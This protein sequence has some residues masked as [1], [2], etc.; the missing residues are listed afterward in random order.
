MLTNGPDSGDCRALFNKHTMMKTTLLRSLLAAG[1]FL[2]AS[3]LATN[4]RAAAGD[5]YE[6]N[7]GNVLRFRL[8]SS[9]PA[10]FFTGLTNPKGLVFDG[11]GHLYIADPGKGAII[12]LSLPD[13]GGSTYASGLNSPT[14][15][16][17][18]AAGFLYVSEAGSGNI[19]KFAADRTKTTFAANTGASAG[20]VFD[21]NGNLFSAD[22]NGGN[23]FK[24]A[25]DG[26]KTTFATGLNH[27]AGLAIDSAGNLFEADSESGTI[28][29]FA[30]DG[31]KTSF[32][33][34]IG[35][36]Y[37]ITFD[38]NGDLI[39]A[40]NA[41]G[42]TLK[43]SPTGVKAVIFQSNFNTPQFVAVEPAQHTLLNISTRG[44]VQPGS[45]P[46]IAG[47]VV[48]GTGPV[49]TAI[50]IR[51]LGPSLSALGVAHPLPDPVVELH[52]ASGTLI[53][54]NNDWKDSQ[55][56]AISATTL[57]PT[58]DREAAILT[59]VG[60]GAFTAVV[61]SATGES[62]TAVVEVYDLP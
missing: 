3:L 27:P 18:D 20:L 22:F 40:D 23:I 43:Y 45:D 29:K 32:V 13:A 26:T 5:L 41:E 53:A 34:G 33:T 35:R 61:G 31:T 8:G 60:G 42:A 54:S 10:Q 50:L 21:K 47:F 51:V 55:Q 6:T 59:T 14:G 19:L 49:G 37:G 4:T 25:P 30:P 38:A 2:A 39:V 12:V 44:L 17:F 1:T 57:A 11:N 7:E 15:V 36:P 9:S 24:F 56:G 46:L 62:G 48:G 58:N 16:A 52:D 28:F